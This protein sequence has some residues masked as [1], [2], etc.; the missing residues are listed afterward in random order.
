MKIPDRERRVT[1]IYELDTRSNFSLL[2]AKKDKK[3]KSKK[4]PVS[5]KKAATA[6]PKAKKVNAKKAP[7]KPLKKQGSKSTPAPIR[8]TAS[9]VGHAPTA[10]EVPLTR[11][12]SLEADRL[13]REGLTTHK[14]QYKGDSGK[15]QDYFAAASTE[16]EKAYAS[17]TVNPHID[18]RSVKSGDWE[19]QVDFNQMQQTNIRH[20]N[21]KVRSIQRVPL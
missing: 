12:Q 3:K 21:H 14:W 7:A 20:P 2:F 5:P 15:F 8:R 4:A 1:Q 6:T 10:D 19:Y 9:T 16:V 13:F 18:V 17:W 11:K